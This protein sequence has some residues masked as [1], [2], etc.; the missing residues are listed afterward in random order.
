[1]EGMLCVMLGG[2]KA[3]AKPSSI[4]PGSF[5]NEKEGVMMT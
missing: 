1:M 5:K 2:R 4:I 3:V